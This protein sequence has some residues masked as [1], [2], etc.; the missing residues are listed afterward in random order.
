MISP[1]CIDENEPSVISRT[2]KH[3]F[4]VHVTFYTFSLIKMAL[5]SYSWVNCVSD[6]PGV[7]FWKV[8]NS[9]W[10]GSGCAVAGVF[11]RSQRCRRNAVLPRPVPA[12]PNRSTET[13]APTAKPQPG[14]TA[15]PGKEQITI[16]N[17]LHGFALAIWICRWIMHRAP[18]GSA[19]ISPFLT[20]GVSAGASCCLSQ[21]CPVLTVSR[22]EAWLA[23]SWVRP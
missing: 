5:L 9:E 11:H 2:W 8:A 10:L 15:R 7:A 4:P 19:Q 14:L 12:P 20:R 18:L 13:P 23:W 17:S 3:C 22:V 16:E 1:V 21:L 6:P